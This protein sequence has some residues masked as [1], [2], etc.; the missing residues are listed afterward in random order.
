MDCSRIVK[1]IKQVEEKGSNGRLCLALYLFFTS[2]I[3]LF[4]LKIRVGNHIFCLFM[5]TQTVGSTHK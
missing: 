5:H 3:K 4:K 2:L 1:F